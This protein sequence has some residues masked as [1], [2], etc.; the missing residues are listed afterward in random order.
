MSTNR[1]F[2]SW[3]YRLVV[4]IFMFVSLLS[5]EVKAATKKYQFNVQVTNVS[6]L[7]HAKPIVTVNG[8]FP[9]PTVYAREGDRVL[10][11]V[12]NRAQYNMSIHWHGL[13]QYAN[14]WADGPAYITQCPIRPGNN[15]VYDFT[16]T[17][18]R[19]T[20]W[21]H[22]HILWLRAT[23]Y[24]AI[25]IL[26]KQTTLFPFPRPDGEQVIVFGEWWHAD[27][28]EVEKQGNALGLPPNMSDAHTINGKPGPLFPCSEKHTFAMEVEQGK[29]YLLRIVNAALNDELFFAI[30]GHN[31]TVVEI[32][33][34][35]TKPF[36][37]NA[38]LIAPGQTTNVIVSANQ[39]P[40]RYFMAVRPFQDVPIPVDNKT[41]TAILQYKNVPT[42]I[43]PTLP[44]LPLPND[45]AFALSY[46]KKL[47]SL[48]TPSFPVNVPL[49][50]DRH[51]FFTI[52]LGKSVCPTCIN[53]TRLSA[54][55]NNITFVMPQV[56]LLQAHYFDVKGVFRADFPDNPPQAFNYTGAPLTANL[57]TAKGTRL[58]KIAFNSTVELVIQD[59]NLLSV[60][61]HPFHL[62]GFNFFVVGT[63]IGNFDPSKDPT[64][65]NLVDPPER[66]TIGVPTGGWA[67]I[68]FR[69]DNPGVWFFHC[70]LELHT[71]W[72]LKT[73]FLVED[74]PG[75]D[76]AVRPPPKDLP[77]C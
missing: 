63:G 56:A 67:A 61:S 77:Q 70:H 21:W 53:G 50:V 13:K 51:L 72:G 45:T 69:A 26:P 17:G 71:G 75:K 76:Q 29:K 19:G 1:A 64:K 43:I 6:R 31:M 25:V 34:V 42:T 66:N 10:I 38:I 35:Y 32:D 68:R 55:L 4:C 74:G 36:T 23:V 46:N 2:D 11:N 20:L 54:S 15:Y 40:G 5:I 12:T 41:A 59:T 60:E 28:E 39:A 73:A 62:H 30:A 49:K 47:L 14:G 65:Y 7:C 37:T 58:S 8:M 3:K 57:F 27:V 33:A 9:G 24:G 44:H 18:Q 16:I 52:G 22:A 48:N